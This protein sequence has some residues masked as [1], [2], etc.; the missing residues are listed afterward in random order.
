[1]D[2]FVK[3]LTGCTLTLEVCPTNEIQEIKEKIQDRQGI[4]P[5]Q[6]RLIFAGK[7]PKIKTRQ[8]IPPEQQRLI[9]AGKGKYRYCTRLRIGFKNAVL[10]ISTT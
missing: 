2:L 9:F 10:T 7:N 5:E 1:M 3:T 4:P 6:Q 8:A